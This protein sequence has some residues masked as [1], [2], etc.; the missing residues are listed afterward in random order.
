MLPI[1]RTKVMTQTKECSSSS[2]AG[3]LANISVPTPIADSF[4][5]R[6]DLGNDYPGENQHEIQKKHIFQ[7]FDSKGSQPA[8]T[9]YGNLRDPAMLL[10]IAESVGIDNKVI[11]AASNDVGGKRSSGY[12]IAAQAK[13]IQKAIPWSDIYKRIE[14]LF[15]RPS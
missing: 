7:W 1:K 12:K 15:P 8:K 3:L 10:W 4:G 11:E 2:F 9:T 13:N 6:G 14:L 5:D